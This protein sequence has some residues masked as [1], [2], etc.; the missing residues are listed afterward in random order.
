MSPLWSRAFR[1]F[2]WVIGRLDPI[3]RP[4]SNRV[5][6]GNLAEVTV[7]GWRSGRR[8]VVLLG[9]LRVD[10]V[11]YLG[12]PNGPTDWT[13]NLDAAAGA[14]ATIRIH[15]RGASSHPRG[16]PPRGRRARA[17]HREH[18]APA[19]LSRVDPV[20]AR[21]PAH[22]RGRPLLPDRARVRVGRASRR[23]ARRHQSVA[24]RVVR[25]IRW[26][27]PSRQGQARHRRARVDSAGGRAARC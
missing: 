16:P 10:G 14:G 9:L 19:A 22:P 15:G 3:I 24:G 6:I 8:R 1:V 2:Y 5:P 18:V 25:A 13:R 7:T 27:R 20:L 17:G 4:V 12:H 21:A 26:R 23:P 11:W